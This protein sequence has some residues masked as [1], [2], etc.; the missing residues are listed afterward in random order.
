MSRIRLIIVLALIF[1]LGIGASLM[2]YQSAQRVIQSSNDLVERALADLQAIA[3]FK[4]DLAEH[5]RRR[6]E[7]LLD[8]LVLTAERRAQQADR[9]NRDQLHLMS[10]MV[11]VY[12]IIIMAIAAATGTASISRIDSLGRLRRAGVRISVDDF[13]TGYSSLAYLSV[14]PISHIKIDKTFVD[15]VPPVHKAALAKVIV[16]LARELELSCIAEGVESRE[17]ADYLRSIGCQ[18][19]QGYFFARPGR[20][21][22]FEATVRAWGA[23]A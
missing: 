10:S 15:D 11:I 16:D 2:V 6:V 20:R 7:P 5:E 12:T 8:D 19:A 4:S 18:F 22:D 21:E 3:S 1:L 13:G 17:Q 9:R 23:A 14:M